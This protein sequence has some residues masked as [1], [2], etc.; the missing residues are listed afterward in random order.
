MAHTRFGS[1]SIYKA[2]FFI[3]INIFNNCNRERRECRCA[4]YNVRTLYSA[5]ADRSRRI[6]K[7]VKKLFKNPLT[8][9]KSSAIILGY[10]KTA[11]YGKSESFPAEEEFNKHS[12]SITVLFRRARFIC[13]NGTGFIFLPMG[14]QSAQ[15]NFGGETKCQ[16]K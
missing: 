3:I 5:I 9:G 8:N 2:S 13:S 11:G 7:I 6:R 10:P 12:M 1:F 15:V 16:A 4:S 14:I